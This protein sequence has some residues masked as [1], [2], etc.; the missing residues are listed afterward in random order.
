MQEIRVGSSR[1]ANPPERNGL[2]IRL[3]K[4]TN[5][6]DPDEPPLFVSLKNYFTQR[7]QSSTVSYAPDLE[8]LL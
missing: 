5:N 2:Q 6:G 4:K 8:H 3:C 7:K 1:I